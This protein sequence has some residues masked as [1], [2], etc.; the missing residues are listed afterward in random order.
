ME[1]E[2]I[3]GSNS[4]PQESFPGLASFKDNV[5]SSSINAS[6]SISLGSDPW[7]I[8]GEISGYHDNGILYYDL[9][10][11]KFINNTG[12][13][14]M[15]ELLRSLLKEGI[16]VRFINVNEKIKKKIK[17]LGLEHILNCV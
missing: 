17:S 13:V 4:F 12:M 9:K 1:N 10:K 5:E 3:Q 6:T 16:E 8:S 2:M 11:V 15:I 7:T 14:K